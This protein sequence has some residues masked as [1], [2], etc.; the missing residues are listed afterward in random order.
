M[1]TKDLLNRT[2]TSIVQN[3]LAHV[4]GGSPYNGSSVDMSGYESVLFLVHTGVITDG[5][6]TLTFEDSADNSAFATVAAADV[7]GSLAG[8]AADGVLVVTTDNNKLFE[9]GYRGKQRYVRVKAV[10]SGTTT[11][12]IYGIT[13]VRSH[14]RS[15]P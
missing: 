7:I 11:G 3:T 2:A 5:T 4:T 6:H 12:G 10:V 13:A 15:N 1:A 14:A 8:N 9:F